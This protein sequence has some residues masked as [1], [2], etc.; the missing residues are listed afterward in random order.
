VI[1]GCTASQKVTVWHDELSD[2]ATCPS[3]PT[4]GKLRPHVVW[5]REMPLEMDAIYDALLGLTCSWRL[6]PQARS[7]RQ[8]GSSMKPRGTASAPVRS[9]WSHR[10]TPGS[11]TR[12]TMDRPVIW[13][14]NGLTTCLQTPF[15]GL[16][17]PLQSSAR[18]VCATRRLL[19]PGVTLSRVAGQN[20][21]SSRPFSASADPRS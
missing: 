8:P 14:R 18:S 11:S 15:L 9:I 7:T 19:T 6:A 20:P 4:A 16:N 10:T 2:E 5:F 12:C 21:R 3:C 17:D 1:L 13:F